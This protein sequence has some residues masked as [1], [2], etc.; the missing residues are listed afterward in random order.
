M[1]LVKAE[2]VY[3]Q[4]L[5][6]AKYFLKEL[7]YYGKNQFRRRLEGNPFTVGE[8]YDFLI[9]STLTY[10]IPRI[11]ECLFSGSEN[12]NGKKSGK[13]KIVFWYGRYPAIFKYEEV[14]AYK[15]AQPESPEKVK[16]LM[17]RFLKIMNK[18][19]QEIDEA[20]IMNKVAHPVFGMLSAVEWYRLI[21]MNFKYHLQAKHELDKVLRSVT[22]EKEPT[23]KEEDFIEDQ[24][25]RDE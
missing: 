7:D 9:N 8:L 2:A 13:G 5:K 6:T 12:I 17:F 18:K 22:P 1:G 11:D 23:E 16:D 19:A 3:Q 21:E 20:E 4:F 15:P 25:Y 14:S 10:Y 24:V